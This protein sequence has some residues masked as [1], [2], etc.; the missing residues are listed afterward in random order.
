MTEEEKEILANEL[1][2]KSIKEDMLDK[3]KKSKRSS[4]RKYFN[5]TYNEGM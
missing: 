2:R 1:R 5:N 3:I 4:A